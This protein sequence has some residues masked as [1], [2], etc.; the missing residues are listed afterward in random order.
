MELF[1]EKLDA[2][3]QNMN[4]KFRN[5]FVIKQAMYEDIVLTLKEGWGSPNFKFWANSNFKLVTIGEQQIV[6]GA[7]NNH[8]V[9][10]Y[11]QMYSKLKESHE[12]VGHH[13]RLS[14]I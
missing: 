9:V 13:G 14:M 8:P 11:E 10:T 12:R 2:H 3:I 6:Y 1:Y 5:K 7:K 4:E